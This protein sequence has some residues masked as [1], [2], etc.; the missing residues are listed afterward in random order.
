MPSN[1]MRRSNQKINPS[2]F[3]CLS[4]PYITY[5]LQLHGMRDDTKTSRFLILKQWQKSQSGALCRWKGRGSQQGRAAVGLAPRLRPSPAIW[6]TPGSLPG[7]TSAE[8]STGMWLARGANDTHAG[9]NPHPRNGMPNRAIRETST[10]LRVRVVQPAW[11]PWE[12]AGMG[13]AVCGEGMWHR[14]G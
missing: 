6:H 3:T 11:R 9:W 8:I 12:P 13:L 10:K 1:G 5:S 4:K 14:R 7:A 2:C